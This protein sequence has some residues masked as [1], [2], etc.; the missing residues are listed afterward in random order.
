MPWVTATPVD[1]KLHTD[2]WN[3]NPMSVPHIAD[4]S[5]RL[6]TVAAGASTEKAATGTVLIT[7][8]EGASLQAL[9]RPAQR[10]DLNWRRYA[11]GLLTS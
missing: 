3:Y 10:R 4:E 2:R 1:C 9:Y 5:E 6:G 7:V 11:T 8:G